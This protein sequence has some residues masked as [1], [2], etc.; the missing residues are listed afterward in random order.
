MDWCVVGITKC[1]DMLLKCSCQCWIDLIRN[2]TNDKAISHAHRVL[3]WLILWPINT[4][5]H[6]DS[7]LVDGT[8]DDD[9]DSNYIVQNVLTTL[10]LCRLQWLQPKP[11]LM[12]LQCHSHCDMRMLHKSKQFANSIRIHVIDGNMHVAHSLIH[13]S[14]TS[15]PICRSHRITDFSM[16]SISLFIYLFHSSI[17]PETAR[18]ID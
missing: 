6:T 17:S 15:P 9:D 8:D 16:T 11:N 1:W 13:A 18:D 14:R 4:H 7:Y 2:A 5:T 3:W 12:K 10:V